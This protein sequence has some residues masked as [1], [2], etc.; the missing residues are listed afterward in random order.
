MTMKTLLLGAVMT[1]ALMVPA[2]AM[3]NDAAAPAAEAKTEAHAEAAKAEP[4]KT[5]AAKETPKETGTAPAANISK[6][7]ANFDANNDGAISE[8]EY[9]NHKNQ[10]NEKY[11]P[12]KVIERKKTM[13]K[14]SDANNDGK[15]EPAEFAA[16]YEKL[17]ARRAE[18]KAGKATEAPK[19]DAAKTEAVKDAPKEEH[20]DAPKEAPAH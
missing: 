16:Y 3:A 10:K 8:D 13:F 9:L 7:F 18:M 5:E 6:A 20:K 17:K 14:E 1:G 11:S 2:L 12:E 4:A 15:V 19:A